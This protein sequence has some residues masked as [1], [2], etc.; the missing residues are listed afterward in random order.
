MVF[1]NSGEFIGKLVEVV[2]RT[3]DTPITGI[4][5]SIEENGLLIVE[6][7]DDDNSDVS[8]QYFI[9]SDNVDYI[10]YSPYW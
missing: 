10:K 6:Y 1:E 4:L 3:D 9:P 2:R 5:T 7:D 8:A